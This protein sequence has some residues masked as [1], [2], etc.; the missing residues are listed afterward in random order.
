VDDDD[1]AALEPLGI[2]IHAVDLGN[3]GPGSSA[4]VV[5]CGPI[6]LLLIQA[7]VARGCRNIEAVEPLVHRREAALGTGAARATATLDPDAPLVDVVFEAAGED[8]AVTAAIEAVRPGGR[9][10]LVGIPDGD[11]TTFPASTA[12]RKGVTFLLSRRM[13]SDAL[14]RAVELTA[15]GSVH[16]GRIISGRYGLDVVV[17]AFA[18][19]VDRRGLKVVVD[20]VNSSV[21]SS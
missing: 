1:A 18:E 2:A 8:A 9:V 7:L 10:V 5:G 11:T 12:R 13:A 19:L 16:P 4:A 6:G 3:V 15:S 14:E 17:D 21:H 20:L